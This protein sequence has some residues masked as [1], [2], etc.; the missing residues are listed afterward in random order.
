MFLHREFHHDSLSLHTQPLP[1]NSKIHGER[2]CSITHIFTILHYF[3]KKSRST[4]TLPLSPSQQKIFYKNVFTRGVLS[5]FTL[6]TH[7]IVNMELKNPWR[8][9]MLNTT[10]FHENPIFSQYTLSTET[11]DT[12]PPKHKAFH[13]NLFTYRVLSWPALV[14]FVRVLNEFQNSLR[15]SDVSNITFQI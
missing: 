8:T 14:T 13:K 11:L 1:R 2:S 5:W 9:S 6:T 3:T 7:T 15:N 10:H 12:S 4:E